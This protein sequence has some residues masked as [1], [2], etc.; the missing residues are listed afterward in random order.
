MMKKLAAVSLLFLVSQSLFALEVFEGKVTM[1]EPSYMPGYVVF[2]MDNGNATC[3]AGVL[4]VWQ[5][6]EPENNKAILG[7][8]MS[9]LIS[10]KKIRFHI[11]NGDTLCKGQYIHLIE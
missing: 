3:P 5:K 6:P 1:I 9:A 10:G 2:R 11:D 8:L 4:L 7:V